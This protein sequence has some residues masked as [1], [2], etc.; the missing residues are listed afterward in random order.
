MA[1]ALPVA[2]AAN[3]DEWSPRSWRTKPVKQQAQ[4]ESAEKLEAAL[5]ERECTRTFFPPLSSGWLG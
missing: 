1:A 5:D 3:T 2:A 4:Y